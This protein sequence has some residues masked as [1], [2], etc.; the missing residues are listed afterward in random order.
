MDLP[1]LDLPFTF[2][3]LLLA[4]RLAYDYYGDVAAAFAG[5]FSIQVF[6]FYCFARWYRHAIEGRAAAAGRAHSTTLPVYPSGTGGLIRARPSTAMQT[7]VVVDPSRPRAAVMHRHRCATTHRSVLQG[8]PA[9]GGDARALSLEMNSR[10]KWALWTTTSS[11]SW[12]L[13]FACW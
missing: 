4:T 10:L 2:L 11:S 5:G 1:W 13:A 12:P 8:R 9:P 7:L 6:L 3:T